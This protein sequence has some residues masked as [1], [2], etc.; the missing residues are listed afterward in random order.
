M[1]LLVL[2]SGVK[3]G[4]ICLGNCDKAKLKVFQTFGGFGGSWNHRLP[5]LQAW[6]YF[7]WIF[8]KNIWKSGRL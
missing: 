4:S 3:D 5:D 8:F 7:S 1:D 2:G 6:F